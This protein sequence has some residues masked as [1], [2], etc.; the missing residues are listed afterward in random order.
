M[1]TDNFELKKDFNKRPRTGNVD[2][3]IINP[4][5]SKCKDGFLSLVKIIRTV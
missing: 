4:D 3:S 1:I 2:F 5:L